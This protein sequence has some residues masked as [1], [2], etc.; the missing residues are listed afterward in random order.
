MPKFLQ[1]EGLAFVDHVLCPFVLDGKRLGNTV[2][3]SPCSV[4]FTSSRGRGIRLRRNIKLLN[5]G[6]AL[7]SCSANSRACRACVAIVFLLQ[8]LPSCLAAPLLIFC[9]LVPER[10]D[11][12][13][14]EAERG[15]KRNAPEV[16]LRPGPRLPSN[17][18]EYGLA[19]DIGT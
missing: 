17:G 5:P 10:L 16:L 9:L 6:Q 12:V 2:L 4:C 13:L 11:D 14:G 19:L 8:S 1:P 7:F 18:I 3:A 15:E